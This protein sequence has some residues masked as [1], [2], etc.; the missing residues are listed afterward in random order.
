M[1]RSYT[2]YLH[3]DTIFKDNFCAF[4]YEKSLVTPNTLLLKK[5]ETH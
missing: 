2:K 3:L 5:F 1:V 4:S